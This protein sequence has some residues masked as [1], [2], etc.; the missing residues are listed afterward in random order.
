MQLGEFFRS[1]P[2]PFLSRA[3]ATVFLGD[4]PLQQAWWS[5]F[6]EKDDGYWPRFHADVMVQTMSAL[7]LPRW[8]EWQA[9]RAPALVVYGE[10]GMFSAEDKAE[11]VTRGHDV[12]R[13]DLPAA[14]H[15]AHLDANGA[16]VAALKS[17]LNS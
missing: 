10:N 1:W 7:L 5:D 15:D 16:W 12:R 9:V 4:G 8:E 13:V 2:I 17:F 3:A 6:E 11:F 14:S